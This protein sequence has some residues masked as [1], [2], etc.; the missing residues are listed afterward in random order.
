MAIPAFKPTNEALAFM[1]LY[2]A[3][4]PQVKEEVK[5]MIVDE[6]DAEEGSEFT[7]LSFQNWDLEGDGLAESQLWERF[8]NERK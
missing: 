5:Q 8:Y 3:M 1:T 4:T 2:K 7:S 6:S